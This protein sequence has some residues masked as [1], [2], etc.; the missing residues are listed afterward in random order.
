MDKFVEKDRPKDKVRKALEAKLDQYNL[1]DS[2]NKVKWL[3]KREKLHK[4]EV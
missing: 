4:N 2:Q 1:S 3:Y